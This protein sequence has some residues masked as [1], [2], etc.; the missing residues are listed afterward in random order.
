MPSTKC[1]LAAVQV[2][3]ISESTTKHGH[4]KL[5]EGVK[6]NITAKLSATSLIFLITIISFT[7]LL[8]IW[9]TWQ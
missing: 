4:G 8:H 1:T 2:I 3:N 6:E 7:A 9:K 5:V